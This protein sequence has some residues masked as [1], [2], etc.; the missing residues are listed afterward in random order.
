MEY[1]FQPESLG[2]ALGTVDKECNFSTAPG[3]HIFLKD[4]PAWFKVPDDGA[5][6]YDGHNTDSD[7][8]QQMQ[9]YEAQQKRAS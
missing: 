7:I 2:I 9:D 4:K 1:Y 8:I 6:R 5:K 3:C